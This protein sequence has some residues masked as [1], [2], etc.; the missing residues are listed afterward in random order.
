VPISRAQ[1][2]LMYMAGSILAFGIIAIIALLIGEA[3]LKPAQFE[4]S[5]IWSVVAFLPEIA[6]PLGFLLFIA[7]IAVTFVTRSR[8]AK[9]AGK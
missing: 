7:L 8:A 4:G 9:D 1:R 2:S 3:S 5:P 6:I